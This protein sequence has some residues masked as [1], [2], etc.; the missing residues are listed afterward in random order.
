M[1]NLYISRNTDSLKIGGWGLTN[2]KIFSYL[3]QNNRINSVKNIWERLCFIMAKSTSD[4]RYQKMVDK[5]TPDSPL[6]KNCIFAFFT[7]GFVCI[8]SELLFSV[9]I[10]WLKDET[11]ARTIVSMS[12]IVLTAIL[13]GIG[14]YDRIAKVAGSGVSVPISGFANSVCAPAIEYSAEGHILGT[15]EK[16]FTIAGAVIVYGCSLASL[17]GMI[18]YFFIKG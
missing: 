12:L 15:A 3:Q 10:S 4:K 5:A 18:Y 9:Y 6:I 11:A 2:R 7:G 8:F 13:T 1:S 17:Y 14:I 16:M